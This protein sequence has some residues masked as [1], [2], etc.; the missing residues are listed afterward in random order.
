MCTQYNI[1]A[2]FENAN[3]VAYISVGCKP[4]VRC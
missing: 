4:Y 3:G 1:I 2:E